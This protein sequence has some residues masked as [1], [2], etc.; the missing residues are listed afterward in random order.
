MK[1]KIIAIFLLIALLVA[2]G[3]IYYLANYSDSKATFYVDEAEY[4]SVMVERDATSLPLP[5][6]PSKPGY[7][8]EGW[9]FD[10]DTWSDKYVEN[11]FAGKKLPIKVA[12]YAKFAPEATGCAHTAGVTDWV[13]ETDSTCTAVG[14]KVQKCLECDAVLNTGTIEKK[15][16]SY[17]GTLDYTVVAGEKRFTLT[18]RCEYGCG[19]RE[20][21]SN[22]AVTT[23]VV[24]KATCTANGTSKYTYIYNGTAYTCQKD[25][26]PMQ[27]H[28][29]NG[30]AH[31]DVIAS[32]GFS[33]D[34]EGIVL[35][36][37]GTPDCG[38]ECDA[39]YVCSVC[40]DIVS[41]RA[42]KV[43]AGTWVQTKETS[44]I[45][46][47][48]E[49]LDVCL[50]C[51]DQNLKRPIAKL[52]HTHVWSLTADA[53][54]ETFTL[55]GVCSTPNCGDTINFE[56][57]SVDV[58]TTDPT[59]MDAGQTVYSYDYDGETYTLT[60]TF[61]P[62]RAHTIRDVLASTYFDA[63]GRLSLAIAD[64]HCLDSVKEDLVCMVTVPGYYVCS[65]CH[66]NISA[67]VYKPHEWL[68][69]ETVNA[70][71]CLVEGDK[72]RGCADCDAID[73]GKLSVIDHP[74]VY[75]LH[76]DVDG[77]R[78]Y[79]IGEC[80]TEGCGA[81]DET[82]SSVTVTHKAIA[83]NQIE[84]TYKNSKITCTLLLDANIRY[85]HTC[86]GHTFSEILDE[87]GK[88]DYTKWGNLA[89]KVIL[90]GNA[91]PEACETDYA[92][93][94]TC[95]DCGV[96]FSVTVYRSH[97]YVTWTTTKEPSCTEI[98]EM[99]SICD[100][101]GCGEVRT[102]DIPVLP[103]VYQYV[104]TGP[105]DPATAV[106]SGE[107]E[108]CGADM[109]VSGMDSI[110]Y[111]GIVSDPTCLEDG[112]AKYICVKGDVTYEVYY[113]VASDPDGHAIKGVLAES[114]QNT[115]GSFNNNIEGVHILAGE[116]AAIGGTCDGGYICSHCNRFVAVTVKIVR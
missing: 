100:Y 80:E 29:L 2:G 37:A 91:E 54:Y 9:Y 40:N 46:E 95:T 53:E 114:K 16:H 24:K 79:L 12:L 65:S 21:L 99:Q 13:T 103:H 104:L 10:K 45:E 101:E 67:S 111:D 68:D 20:T 14:T 61:E 84:Y 33:T 110:D 43:H 63:E 82:M 8:F 34:M 87:N 90:F 72:Q 57:V 108:K 74:F 96:I 109:V 25:D 116:S 64:V 47:G 6:A 60:R 77:D 106:L 36:V 35:S 50:D 23:Q 26:I 56:N 73:E 42:M 66:N 86:G 78:F 62:T 52:A 94:I 31:M 18:L 115:D 41:V 5:D 51:G 102:E 59:C 71:T 38:T 69:W 15:S 1:S 4:H 39:Y 30:V 88:L 113:D 17:D 3:G 22:F 48:E 81:T 98:G 7:V 19:L 85:H 70:S 32:G 58:E 75:T 49:T 97:S 83:T 93:G 89:G 112:M 27:G 92:G 28:K 11:Y 107:C 76:Y 44:C 55:K 105:E